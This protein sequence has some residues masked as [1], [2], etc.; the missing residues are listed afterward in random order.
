MTLTFADTYNMIA[1]LTKSDATTI[2][3]ALRLDDAKSKDCLPNE[4]IFIE[5]SRMGYEKPST[6]LTFYKA[7]FLQQWKF[8]IY[9]LLQCMSAKRMSWNEFSSS[10]AL[11]VICLS[12]GRKFNFS[13]Y[14]FDSL[15]WNVDSSTKFYMYPRFLQLRIEAQVG[16]LSSHT[17][18][19]SSPALT[20]KVFAN[21]RR[22]GKGF[23][24]VETPLFE[25]M[26]A[27]QQADDVTDEGPTS[28]DVDAIPFYLK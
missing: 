18:K 1:Y 20:Q 6:K 28:V 12:T 11:V 21:M 16:D 25:G 23:Y 4:E 7:F 27:A 10:M 8:L 22:V 3:E 26:I 15:V 2:Q 5:L 24:G 17:T 14:I 13:K 9:T 19:Y